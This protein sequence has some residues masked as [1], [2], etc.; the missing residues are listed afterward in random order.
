MHSISGATIICLVNI[1]MYEE[2]KEFILDY[3]M[4]YFCIGKEYKDSFLMLQQNNR[5]LFS[6]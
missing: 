4:V 1:S 6:H 2:G 5:K 3:V